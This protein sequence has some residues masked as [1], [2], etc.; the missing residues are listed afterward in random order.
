MES[1]TMD[2]IGSMELKM[3]DALLMGGIENAVTQL[4]AERNMPALTL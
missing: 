3:L 2:K 1:Q 4:H